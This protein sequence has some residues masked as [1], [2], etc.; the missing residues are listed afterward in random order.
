[1]AFKVEISFLATRKTDELVRLKSEE[2][3]NFKKVKKS[4]NFRKKGR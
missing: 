1:V 2:R 3:K 4:D